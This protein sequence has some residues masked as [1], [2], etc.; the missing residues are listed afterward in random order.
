MSASFPQQRVVIQ[1]DRLVWDAPV[2]ASQPGLVSAPETTAAWLRSIVVLLIMSGYMLLNWPFSQF[3]IPPSGAGIPIGEVVLIL[4]LATMNL[5]RA[6][7]RLGTVVPLLPFLVW[8]GYGVSRAIFD[9]TIYGPWALRDA[10][11]VL[12]SMYLIIAFVMAGSLVGFERFFRWLTPLL[13]IGAC[14][15]LLYPYNEQIEAVSPVVIAG[16]GFPVPIFGSMTNTPYLMIMAAAGLLIFKGNRVWAILT[17]CMLLGFMIAMFQARTLYLI[18]LAMF[19][20]LF[21]Y[22]RSSLG[23]FSM[24]VYLGALLLAA[25]PLL[26]LEF[27]GRLGADFSFGFMVNHFLAIFGAGSDEYKGV[28]A[29]AEGVDMRLEWWRK[30]FDD[31]MTD[32][33]HLLLGLGYGIPLTDFANESGAIVREP[34]N[35]Y[36]SVIARTGLIGALA[37]ATIMISLFRRWHLTLRHCQAIGWR[38]GENRLL[39]LMVF[40]ICIVVL[41][42]GEDGFEKPFNLIPFYIFWGIILRMSYM[43]KRGEIG[44]D[45]AEQALAERAPG[46]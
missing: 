15:G 29:A 21:L 24:I 17:A 43:L 7:S 41:A 12:E 44:P 26:G 9:F 20:F 31:M 40:F 38:T 18:V 5:P 19:G 1:G 28:A 13:A 27:K 46:V 34:H 42:L 30:I 14:Y 4:C 3:R 16:S 2:V 11:H 37:W 23:N 33:A 22:R 45:A 25:I 35:S 10:V 39:L 8:W 32:P 36:I 6:F